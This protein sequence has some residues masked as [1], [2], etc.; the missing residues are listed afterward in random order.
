MTKMSALS[1]ETQKNATINTTY[2]SNASFP[3]LPLMLLAFFIAARF[4]PSSPLSSFLWR[5]SI[6]SRVSPA[7][8]LNGLE[9]D[10]V[11]LRNKVSEKR[12]ANLAVILCLE[13]VVERLCCDDRIEQTPQI[14]FVFIS[15]LTT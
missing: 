5:I 1:H 10:M 13:I 15:W 14:V 3:F 8:S 6:S 9:S 2:A 7:R 12:A 11:Y 4:A